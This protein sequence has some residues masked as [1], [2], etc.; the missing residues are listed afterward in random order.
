[1]LPVSALRLLHVLRR[2]GT[3]TAAAEELR[4]SRSAASHQLAALQRS[5]GIPLTEKLGRGLRLTEAG[6]RLA[7]HAA[8]VLRE[9]EEASAAVERLRGA[10][11]GTV[12]LG[13]V[14][15]IAIK[16]VPGVLTA[17]GEAHPALR[18]ETRSVT[19]EEAMLAVSSGALDL[20]VVPSYDVT[21]LRAV[22]GLSQIR[23]FR[24]P[25]RLALANGHKL[26][27]L[28]RVSVAELA[29]QRWIGGEPDSYF[30]QLVPSLCGREGLH[31]DIVH[32]SEDY[33]VVASLVATGHGIALIPASAGLDT[34]PGITVVD[35]D[36]TGAGRDI[37]VL[38]RTG[39]R[40]RPA[41]RAV[42]RALRS[43]TGPR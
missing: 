20:A 18:L 41:V 1:M 32:R 9:L 10:P 16:V 35:V 6:V 13:A 25:V 5:L 14:Q 23:L 7:E 15:T 38:L 30:G 37:V 40:D 8:T 3:L 43:A 12:M 42:M 34:W 11:A 31:P 36:A 26:A 2:R 33:A 19:T 21:P 29:G 24:D 17:V 27:G 4:L 39:S 28:N 22:D